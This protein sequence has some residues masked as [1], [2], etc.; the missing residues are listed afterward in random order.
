MG[1]PEE[2]DLNFLRKWLQG[3]TEGNNF[4]TDP[5]E[6]LKTWDEDMSRDLVAL[7]PEDPDEGD[8]AKYFSP[9][10][11]NMYD[12]LFQCVSQQPSP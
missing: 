11:V 8:F 1:K 4:Q 5:L 10:F 9:L 6:L 12:Y 3:A 2:D 7:I